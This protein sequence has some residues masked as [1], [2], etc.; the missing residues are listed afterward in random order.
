MKILILVESL[1]VGGGSERFASTLGS[2]LY[3]EGYDISYLTLMEE[4]PKFDFKGE[5]YTL[6]EGNIYGNIFKR[7]LDLF[8]YA[9]K[10]TKLCKDLSIETIISIS[11]IANFHAVLSR[12]LYGNEVRIIASQHINPEIF[13]DSKIKSSLIKFFYQHADTTVCVSK[14]IERILNEKYA[15]QNTT[16]IYNMM[17]IEENLKLSTKKLPEKYQKLFM[18][19]NSKT[20][21]FISI[22]R[23]TRQK[24]HW[25]LIR[26]FRR[27]I[28]VH[29]YAKLFILG[30]GILRNELETLI[31]KL[32][33]EKNV[34]ILGEQK[35]VFTFLKNSDCFV[36]SSLW[37][38][39]GLVLIEALSLDLPV[40][41]TDC[42]A[43]PREILSPELDLDTEIEYP[44]KGEYGILTQ[45]FPNELLLKGTDEVRLIQSEEILSD[46]MI[47]II[48]DEELRKKYSNGL[49]LA[50]NYDVQKILTQWNKLLQS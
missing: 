42:K 33:L 31:K 34:N 39:F 40:I 26:S 37:E 8:R 23:L 44:Y 11:E 20:F 27:L 2:K 24:G 47:K 29:P 18:E 43:G 38:G 6:N 46:L 48:E 9:P 19:N 14:E 36:F 5:Y 10:I 45:N 30:E 22:G 15:I 49:L 1:K 7:T 41:S 13:L 12:Y 25:F 4:N 28:D 17:D 35:N 3:E 16:T 50:E 21:H 32:E